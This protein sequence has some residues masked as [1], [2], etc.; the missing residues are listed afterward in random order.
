MDNTVFSVVT[1][2]FTV[3]G[4]VGSLMAG[5][6]LSQYG[7][8]GALKLSSVLVASGAALMTGATSVA[9]LLI[10]RSAST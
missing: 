9:L 6:F 7:R 1:A 2:S 5:H 8:K 10:G 4:L 3:G